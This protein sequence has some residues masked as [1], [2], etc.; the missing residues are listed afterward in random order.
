MSAQASILVVDDQ[1]NIRLLLRT[2][3]ETEGYAVAEAAEGRAAM[4]AVRRDRP[5]LVVLDLNMPVMDGMAVLEQMASIPAEDRPRVVVL[6]AYG[7]IPAAVRATRLGAADFLEK[8]VTPADLRAVVRSVLTEPWLDAGAPTGAPVDDPTP[9][10][11]PPGGYEQALGQVR[12][13][14]RLVQ[15]DEAE[16]LLTRAAEVRGRQT[17]EYL[18]LLGVL[19]E[20]RHRWRLAR[21]CYGRAIDADEHYEPART[22]FRRIDELHRAGRTDREVAFGDEPA[23]AWYARLPDRAGE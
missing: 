13:A 5:D 22:N 16:G 3:L 14:L 21:R 18:N 19:Y 7:S 23:D 17:A 20:S 2:A 8:P 4:A 10:E 11:V 6:T 15:L 9:A 1:S 12:R